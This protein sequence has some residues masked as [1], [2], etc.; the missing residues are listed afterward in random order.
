MLLVGFYLP[1]TL[2][3]ARRGNVLA[4]KHAKAKANAKDPENIDI[5]KWLLDMGLVS[6][7]ILMISRTLIA[8]GPILVG[9]TIP[10]IINLF[11]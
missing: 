8:L 3:L 11:R 10:L 9:S 1:T 2:V 6:N 5:H 7:P 4:V